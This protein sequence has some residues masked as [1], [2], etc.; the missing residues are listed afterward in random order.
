LTTFYNN[1][2]DGLDESSWSTRI[3]TPQLS[4]YEQ[5]I[6]PTQAHNMVI[7]LPECPIDITADNNVIEY[8]EKKHGRTIRDLPQE[9]SVVLKDDKLYGKS[10]LTSHRMLKPA[11]QA[12]I[13]AGKITQAE[14][15]DDINNFFFWKTVYKGVR[16][17]RFEA[18]CEKWGV[19]LV[20]SE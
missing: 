14:A 16:W 12:K 18:I 10:T 3:G 20:K 13:E 1:K 2:I 9:L 15:E 7:P 11:I 4:G 17:A 6:I 19:K 5:N 8:V